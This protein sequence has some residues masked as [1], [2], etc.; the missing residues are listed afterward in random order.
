MLQI[1]REKKTTSK[2]IITFISFHR[3]EQIFKDEKLK[4]KIYI[5]TSSKEKLILV[6]WQENHFL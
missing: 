4:E 1:F 3:F 6:T 5:K 2:K